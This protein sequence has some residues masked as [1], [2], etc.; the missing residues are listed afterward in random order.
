MFSWLRPSRQR[1][2]V[3]ENPDAKLWDRS[4]ATIETADSAG[5][6][7]G[8][9]GEILRPKESPVPLTISVEGSVLRPSF[10]QVPFHTETDLD[11]ELRCDNRLACRQSLEL[12][13]T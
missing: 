3:V 1:I 7:L 9:N 12:D 6:K 10:L 13:P 11:L 8:Y 2:L 4:F 5:Q